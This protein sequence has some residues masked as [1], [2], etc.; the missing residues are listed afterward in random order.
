MRVYIG[1]YIYVET[2]RYDIGVVGV[3]SVSCVFSM[4]VF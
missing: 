3:L 1:M 4:G 2:C